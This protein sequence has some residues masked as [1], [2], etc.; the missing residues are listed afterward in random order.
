MQ[1]T[2]LKERSDFS[3]NKKTLLALLYLAGGQ[4]RRYSRLQLAVYALK[5][6][7][8]HTY[9]FDEE[10]SWGP[11]D[12]QFH[13]D[14]HRLCGDITFRLYTARNNEVHSEYVLYNEMK[15]EAKNYAEEIK[16]KNP[17]GYRKLKQMAKLVGSPP[18]KVTAMY[19]FRKFVPE[20]K[21]L[22]DD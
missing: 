14:L 20:Y 5:D 13:D 10:C 4:I 6:Y 19:L 11:A 12:C 17:K 3:K 21:Q 8:L 2:V 18:E 9:K 15:G 16:K 1:K 22:S 7:S